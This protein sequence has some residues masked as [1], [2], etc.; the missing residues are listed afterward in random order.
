MRP[1]ANEHIQ[2]ALNSP[3]PSYPTL[4]DSVPSAS[5]IS[6]R[7]SPAKFPPLLA[8]L[9]F[10]PVSLSLVYLS[11]TLTLVPSVAFLWLKGSFRVR[12]VDEEVLLRSMV[13]FQLK[14]A[15]EM[16]RPSGHIKHDSSPASA[17]QVHPLPTAN[18]AYY[19]L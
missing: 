1:L 4:R 15:V 7:P 18:T 3:T 12:Y 19:S 14:L 5:T 17:A 8:R 10:P 13:R 9:S 2:Y 11:I 6:L 16:D